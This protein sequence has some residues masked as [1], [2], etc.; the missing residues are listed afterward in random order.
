[1]GCG[2]QVFGN[3]VEAEVFFEFLFRGERTDVEDTVLDLRVDFTKVVDRRQLADFDIGRL[4]GVN[5]VGD[6]V[7]GAR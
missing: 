6:L 1:M 4:F 2:E 3:I 7:V 5:E